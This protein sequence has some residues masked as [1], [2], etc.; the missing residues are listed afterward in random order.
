MRSIATAIHHTTQSVQHSQ[1]IIMGASSGIGAA[2]TRDFSKA[3]INVIALAR[4][5]EKLDKLKQELKDEPGR[6]TTIRCDV[7]DKKSVEVAFKVIESTFKTVNILVN[8]AG[9]VKWV[10]CSVFDIQ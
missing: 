9:V 10:C 5:V 2:I 1:S 8:N 7:S 6:V 3:G 4:R